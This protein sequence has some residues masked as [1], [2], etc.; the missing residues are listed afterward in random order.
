M[1]IK[2]CALLLLAATLFGALD[3]A[4]GQDFRRRAH[5]ANSNEFETEDIKAEIAFGREVAARILGRAPLRDNA[6]LTRYITLIGQALA[7]N[8][9][10]AEL[11]FYFAV[12]DSEQV[13]AYSTPGGYVF[14]TRGALQ[15]M[16]D[17]AE[18]A[19][20][21]A[22]EIAH[23]Q[24]RHIVNAMHIRGKETNNVMAWMSVI[25][26]GSADTAK[27]AFFQAVDQA[28]ALLFEEGFN[29]RDE[30]AADRVALM[31]LANTGY[32]PEALSRFLTRIDGSAGV[33]PASAPDAPAARNDKRTHPSSTERMTALATALRTHGLTDLNLPRRSERFSTYAKHY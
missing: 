11:P 28:T 25:T 32:D 21:L 4:A 12:L 27:V 16:H 3:C 17:E 7:Y 1:S 20:V 26:G 23:V 19:A 33:P 22:H 5:A 24:L 9:G 8:S 18:L 6:E 30:L 31:L 15:Q 10:R 2:T 29:I 13:N 14:V